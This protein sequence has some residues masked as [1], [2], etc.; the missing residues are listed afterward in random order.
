M[1]DVM[2]NYGILKGVSI[3][4]YYTT[5]EI[6]ECT[7]KEYC[8]LKTE[9]GSF[10]PRFEEDG[11]RTKSTST[12]AFYRSGKLKSVALNSREMVVTPIG[13]IKSELITFYEN[14]NI[15]K[16]FPVNGKITAFWTEQNEY[17]L[18]EIIELKLKIG[19]IKTKVVAL[20]F[21]ESKK[22]KSIT[23]WRKDRVKLK[24]PIGIV[25][26]RMGLALYKNGEIKSLEP[27]SKIRVKTPIGTILAYD[28]N[29]IGISGDKNSLCFYGNGEIKSL[30]TSTDKIEIY[31]NVGEYIRS[32]KPKLKSSLFRE[33]KLEVVPYKVEFLGD[34][35]KFGNT[36]E[37]FN[38]NNY[39]F[40][41]VNDFYEISTNTNS[42]SS[43]T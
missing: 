7:L 15:K 17:E 21:Y 19:Q 9:I 3:A 11:I 36:G 14:G 30:I 1:V 13:N 26:V 41:I 29:A 10:V 23:F 28:I 38:I 16:V 35:V 31:N 18:A 42:C 20:S 22:L 12:V 4:Q 6:S 34:R 43:C 5:G 24:T 27:L 32:I 39:K 33:D 2:T 8:E 25:E 37:V 40:R